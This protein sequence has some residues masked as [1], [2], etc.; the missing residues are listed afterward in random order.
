ML[1]RNV[2][3]TVTRRRRAAFTL[4]LFLV[5]PMAAQIS[6]STFRHHYIARDLPGTGDWGYGMASLADYDGDGDL[7]YTVSSRAGEVYWFEQ[8]GPDEW[9]RHKVGAMEGV[10]LGAAAHD[11]DHDGRADLVT[12][13]HWY[14]N[15]GNPRK[16]QFERIEYDASIGEIHDVVIAD[17]DGD[18]KMDVLTLGDRDGCQWYSIPDDP[19]RHSAWK[20]HTVT[21]DV[22]ATRE[23]IHAGIFPRGAGDLDGDGDADVV[24]AGRWYE[25]GGKG[26]SWRKHML[27]LGSRGPYGISS[28][29]WIADLDGDGD[30]DIVSSHA[31]Q[32]NSA[33]AWLENDGKSP[34]SFTVHFMPNAAPGTRGSFH[35]L[36]VAD[37]DLDGDLDVLTAEQEDPTLPPV[38]VD[39]RRWFV[40]ENLGGMK[41]I[42]RVILD[43][44]LGGHD[45]LA[46]DL[47][48]DGDIDLA[49]KVW[50][51]WPGSANKGKFHADVL[52]NLTRNPR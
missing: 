3:G 19:L 48:G 11:V 7:D 21:L 20:R 44:G 35:S 8:R 50:K 17:V 41:F 13:R 29:S 38:G 4:L 18:G 24:I 40:F 46:G 14:R 10:Q 47:D 34:P 12:G 45:V 30:A 22:L 1:A 23:A 49:S 5:Q 37:F 32:Q 28:R 52:V 42:E 26:L 43:H 39:G 25:N 27:P 9:I 16:S 51:R 6:Q 33:A 15:P 31:D 36:A 2:Y